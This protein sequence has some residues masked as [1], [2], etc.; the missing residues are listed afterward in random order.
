MCSSDLTGCDCWGLV[1]IVHHE[2]AGIEIP[3]YTDV[4]AQDYRRVVREIRSGLESTIWMDVGDQPRRA[5]DVVVMS[6]LDDAR[7][8]EYH[9]GIMLSPTK[10]LH[11]VRAVGSHTTRLTDPTLKIVAYRRHKDLA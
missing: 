11:T 9:V 2:Q 3:A 4:D 7:L 10:M 8:F 5:M 6:K 1:R